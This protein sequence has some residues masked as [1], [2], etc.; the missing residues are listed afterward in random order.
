MD[1]N[2]G[3]A[4]IQVLKNLFIERMIE[5]GPGV[6]KIFDSWYAAG[7]A[8][9]EAMKGAGTSSKNVSRL[10]AEEEDAVSAAS[11]RDG[12]KPIEV[13]E[14]GG[15]VKSVYVVPA[16][17]T[18][19]EKFMDII[20]SPSQIDWSSVLGLSK[21]LYDAKLQRQKEELEKARKE[22]E[23]SRSWG[24]WLKGLPGKIFAKCLPSDED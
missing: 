18:E 7:A 4:L 20:G 21:K 12:V 13:G 6:K 5:M 23:K 9:G 22:L 3:L 15:S 19:Q 16:N 10:F 8:M 1:T 2:L 14:N 24:A 17:E 11:S